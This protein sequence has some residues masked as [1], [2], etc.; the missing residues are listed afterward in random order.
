MPRESRVQRGHHTELS[1]AYWKQT[2]G[3]DLDYC[4]PKTKLCD[5]THV[6]ISLIVV[7]ISRWM[8]LSNDHFVHLQYLHT[9]Q[10]CLSKAGEKIE[11]EPSP[12]PPLAEGCLGQDEIG[13]L[14]KARTGPQGHDSHPRLHSLTLQ[15]GAPVATGTH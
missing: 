8:P 10:L 2:E 9:C 12:A 1:D 11:R 4:H 3:L 6:P 14:A 15:I 5:M 13:S 7:I